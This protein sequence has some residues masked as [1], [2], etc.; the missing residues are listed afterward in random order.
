MKRN[1]FW[2]PESKG[3]KINKNTIEV[4]GFVKYQN[5]LYE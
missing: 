4:F 1:N 2:I 5:S 3:M